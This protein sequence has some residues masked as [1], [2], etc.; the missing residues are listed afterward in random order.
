MD[1]KIEDA[2]DEAPI[3]TGGQATMEHA[4][5][6]EQYRCGGQCAWPA[7]R[8]GH[9]SGY[10][11][12]AAP[13]IDQPDR[14][15]TF[16]KLDTCGQCNPSKQ[17]LEAQAG[18][19]WGQ[20]WDLEQTKIELL[21]ETGDNVVVVEKP[22]NRRHPQQPDAPQSWFPRARQLVP[23]FWIIKAPRQVV[24]IEIASR[25]VTDE[26]ERDDIGHRRTRPANVR[27]HKVSREVS[28]AIERSDSESRHLV[29]GAARQALRR[30]ARRMQPPQGG[31]KPDFSVKPALVWDSTARGEYAKCREGPIDGREPGAAIRVSRRQSPH[32]V[33]R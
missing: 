20:G 12:S 24:G 30:K 17:P 5:G 1:R 10:S 27:A 29:D 11:C 25:Q 21:L 18:D 6:G 16:N 4:A 7:R 31:W 22:Q 23:P 2:L 8:L 9:H 28:E 13:P 15:R 26:G 32:A 33:R 3:L 14:A 19:G